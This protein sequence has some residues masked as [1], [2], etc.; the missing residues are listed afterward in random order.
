VTL[1]GTNSVNVTV[2]VTTTAPTTTSFVAP[3]SIAP[4][5]GTF[6]PS[7]LWACV[8]FLPVAGLFLIKR[9][10][11]AAITAFGAV[12]FALIACGGGSNSGGGGTTPGTPS[13]TY[14]LKITGTD[15]GLVHE[16][17]VSLTVQ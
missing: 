15:G 2:T 13:G 8:G 11:L 14:N 9:R 5:D 4:F 10:K 6:R 1:D 12:A 3:S 7:V 17:T 16:S